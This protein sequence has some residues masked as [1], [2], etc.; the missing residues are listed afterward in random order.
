[1][2]IEKTI[3]NHTKALQAM[4]VAMER[5]AEALGK[6]S[7]FTRTFGEEAVVQAQPPVVQEVRVIETIKEDGTGRI[8]VV[9]IDDAPPE[10]TDAQ[11]PAAEPAKPE[12]APVVEEP[13]AA[14]PEAEMA[15]APTLQQVSDATRAAATKNHA[16]VVAL[17]K[18]YGVQKAGQIQQDKW[19]A[20]IA[21]VEAL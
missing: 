21:D 10:Q 15:L 7:V 6:A 5:I 1:M 2:S 9:R 8:D 11:A 18:K 4:T 3:E 12:E 13:A 19:A 17:L 20:Y 16:G 14:A